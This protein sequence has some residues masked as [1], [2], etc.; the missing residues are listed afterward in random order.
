M[1]RPPISSASNSLIKRARALRLRKS[2]LDTDLFV[3]EGLHLVGEAR[4]AGWAIDSILY[5]PEVLASNFGKA[6][7]AG[8]APILQPVSSQVMQSLADKENPQGILAIVHQRHPALADLSSARRVVAMVSPQDPGNV[9]TL[10][11]TMDATDA[12]ALLLLD[13][14]VDPYHPTCVRASMGAIFWK[15]IVKTS[16][17]EMLDWTKSRGV[18]LVGTSAHAP[19]DYR[20]FR[21]A[22]PWMLVLGSEQKGLTQEQASACDVA[23]ALPMRGRASSLNVAVAAGILLYQFRAPI[24]E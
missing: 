5:A 10:L 8:N 4:E 17:S 23:V 13:G 19:K 2:R 18:T 21:P 3:V 1:S 9:G 12:D 7:L 16:F 22:E 6:L 14:G 24:S 20:S 11:R 15:P